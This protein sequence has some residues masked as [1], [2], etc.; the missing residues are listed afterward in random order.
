MSARPAPALPPGLVARPGSTVSNLTGGWRTETPRFLVQRCT[1]C[2]VCVAFCPE[3]IVIKLGPKEYGFDPRY[4]KGCGIC[5]QECPVADIV[6][7]AE[8]R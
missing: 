4:C 7:E 8:V 2:D 3:G 6:M 1:G 5:A